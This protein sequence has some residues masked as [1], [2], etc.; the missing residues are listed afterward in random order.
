MLLKCIA[1]SRSKINAVRNSIRTRIEGERQCDDGEHYVKQQKQTKEYICKEAR[2][3]H[4]D[5]R[6]QV[7]ESY[8]KGM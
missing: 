8:E 3:S 1:Q 5:N 2:G 4:H 6:T 7:F